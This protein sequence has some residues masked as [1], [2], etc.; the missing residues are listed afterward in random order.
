[1]A[2]KNT[3]KFNHT[4][5][6]FAVPLKMKYIAYNRNIRKYKERK[7]SMKML[8]AQITNSNILV[9]ILPDCFPL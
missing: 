6:Y 2:L 3:L 9:H 4:G 8:H 5:C 1:M 7:K